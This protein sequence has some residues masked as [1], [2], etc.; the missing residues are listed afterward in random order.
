MKVRKIVSFLRE[1]TWDSLWAEVFEDNWVL[2]TF[3]VHFALEHSVFK[4]TGSCASILGAVESPKLL[5]ELFELF[6]TN[7]DHYHS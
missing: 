7:S 2:E 1:L 4:K 6:D 3:L 5:E